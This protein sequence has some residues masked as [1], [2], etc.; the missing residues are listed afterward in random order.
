[1]QRQT[2]DPQRPVSRVNPF[3]VMSVMERA[4]ELEKQGRDIVHMEV[5]EPDFSTAPAI[6]EAGK[7]ALDRGLTQYTPAAGIPELRD[8]LVTHYA[9]RYGV[10]VARERIFITPGASGGLTLLAN[11][12][13]APGDGV[14]LSDP[15]YPCVRNFIHLMSAEPQL[16]PV[17]LEQNF[18]PGTAQLEAHYQPNSKGLWLA[19]PSNPTGTILQR[20]QLQAAC[21]WVRGKGLHLLVDEIYHGLHYVDDL[22][23]VLELDQSCFVVNSFSKYYGMTGWR[24]GWI[25]VPEEFVS[26]TNTLAQNLY[27]SASSI[28]Q[29]AAL[30]AF[31]DEARLVFEQRRQAFRERGDYL[32]KALKEIGFIL[33][34][35][36]QGA[37]YIYANISKFSADCEQFCHQMLEDHGVAITP[38]TD[39]G[40]YE[41]KKFVRF[42]F[43][44]DMASLQQ[45][46]E[47]LRKA[48]I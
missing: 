26:V 17:S 48:L 18:Q 1:M 23:S 42:A 8:C 16:I 35:S 2:I 24:L 29:Y 34:D 9:Q 21:D 7:Q 27:I 10:S 30:A 20:P 31:T 33:A 22:P 12:L 46:V 11:L 39:F 13:I 19:S 38:G 32:S 40:E 4:T 43:T 37:F 41:C 6:I 44:T 47:R 28:A 15:A 45:G 5:G 36:I 25:V 3:R 14:L